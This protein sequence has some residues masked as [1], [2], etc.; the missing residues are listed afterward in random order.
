MR[1][2][3]TSQCPLAASHSKRS[4]PHPCLLRGVSVRARAAAIGFLS[5]P[6]LRQTATARQADSSSREPTPRTGSGCRRM[7]AIR[8]ILLALAVLAVPPASA[9]ETPARPAQLPPLGGDPISDATD[10]LPVE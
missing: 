8:T 7:R 2:R 10:N 3:P 5:T 6:R 4:G 1:P 9:S